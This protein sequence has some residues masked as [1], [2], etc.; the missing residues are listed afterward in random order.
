MGF[1]FNISSVMIQVNK[2][3]HDLHLFLLEQGRRDSTSRRFH[4]SSGTYS[5]TVHSQRQ[6]LADFTTLTWFFVFCS[7]RMKNS[8]R[9]WKWRLIRITDRSRLRKLTRWRPRRSLSFPSVLILNWLRMLWMS[10]IWLF[11]FIKMWR[12]MVEV[13]GEFWEEMYLLKFPGV[14]KNS[15]SAKMSGK[16]Y[17]TLKTRGQKFSEKI[18]GCRK[19]FL[20]T[21]K[22]SRKLKK[23]MKKIFN[24]MKCQGKILIS[25]KAQINAESQKMPEK[26]LECRKKNS[27]NWKMPGKIPEYR[28]KCLN[29]KKSQKLEKMEKKNLQCLKIQK[30]IL[31]CRENNLGS[32]VG[33]RE[34]KSWMLWNVRL[35][36]WTSG[37]IYWSVKLPKNHKSRKIQGKISE[38]KNFQKKK[39]ENWKMPEKIPEYRGKFLNARKNLRSWKKNGEKNLQCRKLWGEISDCEKK[40]LVCITAEKNLKLVKFMEKILRSSKIKGK[41]ESRK[42]SE[43]ILECR[44]KWRKLK[45]VEI[46]ISNLV[47]CQVKF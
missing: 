2:K 15:N 32:W 20:N 19:K 5:Q 31:E 46:K 43:K 24:V 47:K 4:F 38:V 9:M 14:E 17:R 37:K 26:I 18:V 11:M 45:K 25:S 28:A 3:I 1:V 6:T 36:S 8:T 13:S 39:S 30:K 16:Y 12:D 44:K 34:D 33:S 22:K 40:I 42:M 35:N 10:A 29:P 21:G 41:T 7:L 27:E 23:C